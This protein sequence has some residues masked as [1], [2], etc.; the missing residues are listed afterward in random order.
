MAQAPDALI[1]RD[2][3]LAPL[4]TSLALGTDEE[5]RVL[6]RVSDPGGVRVVFLAPGQAVD[7]GER[8]AALGRHV[9]LAPAKKR[10]VKVTNG[11]K[12]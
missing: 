3:P 5:G 7:L 8:M 2:V 4:P 11:A 6:L 12:R 9:V 10:L 1:P